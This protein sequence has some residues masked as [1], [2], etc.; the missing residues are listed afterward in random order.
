[1]KA[2]DDT[3]TLVWIFCSLP[4][5][6]GLFYMAMINLEHRAKVAR[7]EEAVAN[8]NRVLRARGLDGQLFWTN[9]AR[10]A[11]PLGARNPKLSPSMQ[12]ATPEDL[13]ALDAIKEG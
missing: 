7:Y 4:M 13:D 12:Q 9:L 3:R 1:M 8:E 10:K 2:K 11:K 5:A 6:F